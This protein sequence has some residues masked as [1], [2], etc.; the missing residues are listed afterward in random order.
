MLNT[1]KGHCPNLFLIGIYYVHI[2]NLMVLKLI[3]MRLVCSAI[4]IIYLNQEYTTFMLSLTKEKNN[5][6]FIYY[7][8]F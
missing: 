2:F 6:F 4:V 8:E 7:L 3:L 5:F 1:L